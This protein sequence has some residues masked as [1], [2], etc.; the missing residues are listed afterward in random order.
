MD[1]LALQSV[2][3]AQ[4]EKFTFV[5]HEDKNEGLAGFFSIFCVESALSLIFCDILLNYSENLGK[6]HVLSPAT[7]V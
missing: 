7:N 5:L 1:G 4:S 2:L 6:I 3:F